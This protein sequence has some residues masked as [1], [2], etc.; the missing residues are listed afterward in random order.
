MISNSIMNMNPEQPLFYNTQD[1]LLSQSTGV[2]NL[3]QDFFKDPSIDQ[4]INQYHSPLSS[5][6]LS[7][8]DTLDSPPTALLQDGFLDDFF[9]SPNTMPAMDMFTDNSL[10]QYVFS[11]DQVFSEPCSPQYDP[12]THFESAPCKP[13]KQRHG[14]TTMS[15]KVATQKSTRPARKLECFNCKVT[16]TPLWRR[17]PDRHHSLCNACGLYYKQ[18]NCHRPLH[19]RNKTHT[20]RTHPYAS[21][22]VIP[23]TPTPEPPMSDMMD[24]ICAN[25]NQTQTPLWRKNDRGEPV[26]NACGLYAKLHHRDRPAEM[27][28]TTI[29]RRR[30]DWNSED[31]EETEFPMNHEINHVPESA[32]LEVEDSRFVSLLLQMDRDQMNG[33]LD[34][35]ERRCSLLKSLIQ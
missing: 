26:C 5:P 2:D 25:C 9:N 28:K 17:T 11:N 16:K 30:R 27:R 6:E 8:S 3:F 15:I 35:L 21:E 22:R 34:I 18:Y 19:V 24:Q 4:L 10:D 7:G 14:Q 1:P 13:K 12:P 33:F 32:G 23:V 29:Q 20:I 31:G